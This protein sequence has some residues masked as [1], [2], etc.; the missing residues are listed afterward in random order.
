MEF[1]VSKNGSATY[2]TIN[3]ALAAAKSYKD[4]PVTIFIA[5]GVYKERLEIKKP[6]LTLAKEGDGEVVITESYYARMKMEDGSNRGTFRTYT[7]LIDTHDFTANDITIRNDAGPG[8]EVGQAVA[9][10]ADG[11]RI[12]FNNCRLIG[13]QDTLFTGPLPPK[14]LQP[15]GFIGPKQFDPRINGRQYYNHCYICG[16]VDFI[17]GSATAYFEECE[18]YSINRN[19][20]VN[21]YCTAPSTPEGQEFGYVFE[22]CK[23]TSNCQDSTVYL[24]RPWRN[25]AKSVFLNC[26]LGAHI[27]P[28]G[29]HDWNKPDAHATVYYAEYNSKGPGSVG[30]RV[31]FFQML[32]SDQ[33]TIYSRNNVLGF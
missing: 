20:E 1:H 4:E 21:G 28:E 25:F 22:S 13:S 30:N 3:E 26:E 10:Y 23:F 6:F 16:D 11:D 24:S 31:D 12:T 14:E 8:D 19:K 18:I 29:I 33:A 2:K 15:N 7:M 9:V 27:K 5:P 17:F 32:N